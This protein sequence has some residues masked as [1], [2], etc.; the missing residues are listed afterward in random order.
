LLRVPP[1]GYG[2]IEKII[3][4]TYTYLK[5]A[6]YEVDIIDIPVTWQTF[7][8][9]EHILRILG[10]LNKKKYDVIH[11][12]SERFY[13]YF[14][15]VEKIHP[16]AKILFT[17]H[18]PWIGRADEAN[19][20]IY[21]EDYKLI[22]KN[23]KY[24]NVCVSEKD[25]NSYSADGAD[26]EKMYVSRNGCSDSYRLSLNPTKANRSV[27]LAAIEKRKRQY[28]YQEIENLDFIGPILDNYIFDSSKKNYLGYPPTDYLLENLTDY[29]NIVLL[30]KAE[31]GTPLSVQEALM[32]GLGAVI[33]KD[34]AWEI[35]KKLPFIS[36]IEDKKLDDVEY[37]KTVIE[38]NRNISLNMRPH[39]RK[40]A[41]ERF[42]WNTVAKNYI[43]N[44]KRITNYEI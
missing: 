5:N 34:A 16:N 13:R 36:V 20:P 38:F 26:T 4:E 6:G 28:V 35:D 10:E 21:T 15:L 42:S 30:T 23:T 37:V 43:D 27:Y 22:I 14:Y 12:H 9:Q 11:F 8:S 25:F 41:E 33:S 39:I 31:N 2:A 44:L 29:G 1:T 7:T 19:N 40:Y 32:A 24:Y 17:S 3:W 18:C